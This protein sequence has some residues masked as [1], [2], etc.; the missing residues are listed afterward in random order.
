MIYNGR[1]ISHYLRLTNH[2]EARGG[3]AWKTKREKITN[4]D[5][6]VLDEIHK[7]AERQKERTL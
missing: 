6:K 5:R 4:A 3:D 1:Y 7:R 2:D